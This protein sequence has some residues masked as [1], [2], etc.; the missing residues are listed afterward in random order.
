VVKPPFREISEIACCI[1]LS[2]RRHNRL[3]MSVE[4]GVILLAAGVS[5]R[6]G[7]I[8]QLVTYRDEPLVRHTARLALAVAPCCVAVTGA[9]SQRVSK[10]LDDLPLILARNH[11]WRKGMAGSLATGIKHLPPEF[12][13]ALILLCDQWRLEI[14]DL[15]ELVSAWQAAPRQIAVA[16]WDEGF[17]PPV[18]FPRAMFP[19]LQELRGDKGA[20]EIVS[21][22]RDKV[23]RVPMQNAAAD[24]DLPRDLLQMRRYQKSTGG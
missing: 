11:E 5:A 8:K 10:A 21:Q 24:L 3:I 6:L 15:E 22:Q 7:R 18:I 9:A 20:R 19:Q 16:S 4:A 23:I 17:G 12:D 13:A 14:Q 1:E 2:T